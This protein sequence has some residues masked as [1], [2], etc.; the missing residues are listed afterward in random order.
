MSSREKILAAIKQNKP[1]ET[2]LQTFDFSVAEN[3]SIEKFKNVLSSIGGTCI[4]ADNFAAIE[5]QLGQHQAS[6]KLFVQ[7]VQELPGYNAPEF[8]NADT[9]TIEAVDTVF[10]KAE[11]AVAENGS[12]W[13]PE[14]NMYNRL[15]PFICQHLVVMVDRTNLVANMHEAYAKVKV[16]ADGFGAFIAGP[17][18][19]ADIEQSLVI[20]AHGP[21]SHTVYIVG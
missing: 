5:E 2:T 17:S 21:L 13:V 14:R 1:A 11:V 8:M 18:K 6:G 3:G 4:E 7:L 15:L 12:V 10:M 20:G 16:D 19:T 9:L